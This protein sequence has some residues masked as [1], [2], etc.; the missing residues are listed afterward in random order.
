MDS[1]WLL[2]ASD[3]SHEHTDRVMKILIRFSPDELVS[4]GRITTFKYSNHFLMIF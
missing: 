2:G 1:K 4:V 3:S